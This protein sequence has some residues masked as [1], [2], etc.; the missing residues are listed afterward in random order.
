MGMAPV[1]V[2]PGLVASDTS[3]RRYNLKVLG[4]ST[5]AV[6]QTKVQKFD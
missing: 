5:L 3:T 6:V 1:V 4:L 2:L